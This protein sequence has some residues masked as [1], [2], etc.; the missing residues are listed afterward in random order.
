MSFP[1][2]RRGGG[3]LLF[4]EMHFLGFVY[5]DF[6]KC[7]AFFFRFFVCACVSVYLCMYLRVCVFMCVHICE[8]LFVCVRVC[9][10]M[11][12]HSDL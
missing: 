5:S 12:I 3:A 1:F 6:G 11:C 8:C 4:F 7:L 10:S 2:F 9:V